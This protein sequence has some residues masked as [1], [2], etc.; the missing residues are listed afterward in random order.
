MKIGEA[1]NRS[2]VHP[3]RR[4]GINT[5]YYNRS[6]IL[7]SIGPNLNSCARGVNQMALNPL[8]NTKFGRITLK[9][10]VTYGC[11]SGISSAPRT[12]EIRVIRVTIIPG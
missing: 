8:V 9:H 6:L 1:L 11:D 7:K 3:D 10:D 5:T 12:G 4:N 2:K